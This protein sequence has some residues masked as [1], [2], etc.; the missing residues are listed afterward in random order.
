MS[1]ILLRRLTKTF[2][3]FEKKEGV[4]SHTVFL[5]TFSSKV[6]DVVGYVKTKTRRLLE[7]AIEPG[8]ILFNIMST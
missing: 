2:V 3:I 1:K 5:G 6:K 4:F 8:L 7:K